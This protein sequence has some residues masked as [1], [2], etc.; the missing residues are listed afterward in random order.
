VVALLHAEKNKTALFSFS[1]V[2]N[3]ERKE[4]IKKYENK[5][6]IMVSKAIIYTTLKR[7]EKKRRKNEV[8]IEHAPPAP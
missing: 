7:K 1:N 4:N 6:K 3:E 5:T 2:K 8:R